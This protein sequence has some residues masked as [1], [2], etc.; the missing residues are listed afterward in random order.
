MQGRNLN[1]EDAE[2]CRRIWWTIYLLDHQ[3]TSLVGV[4]V[5]MRESDIQARLPQYGDSDD[6]ADILDVHIG[7][8]RSMAQIVDSMPIGNS[9]MDKND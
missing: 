9:T 2:R 3:M 7:L 5:T 8:T 4:P 1:N 6:K